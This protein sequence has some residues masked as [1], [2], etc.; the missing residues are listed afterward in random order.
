VKIVGDIKEKAAIVALNKELKSV[1]RE[2]S[3][4]NFE[5]AVT[6][7]FIFDADDREKYQRTKEFIAYT[8]KK[9][10]R[11]FGIGYTAKSE[12]IAYFPYKNGVSYFGLDEVNWY[13]K[14]T[15]PVV[16][17]FLKRR[18]D[19][20]LDL[21]QADLFPTHYIFALSSAKFKITNN[22]IKAK[23][24][25]FVLQVDNSEKLLTYIE[26]IKHYLESIKIKPTS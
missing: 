10:I 11:I 2:S 5:S 9:D 4:Q 1:K 24:A 15:N 17:D 19:L 20:L 25:D 12:Q 3:I 6:A 22:N 21:T 8:E 16:S 26:Q 7:G 14:P 18:Y 13:G 23:Y